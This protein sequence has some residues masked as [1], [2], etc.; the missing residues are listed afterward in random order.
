MSAVDAVGKGVLGT[1]GMMDGILGTSRMIDR[2]LRPSRLFGGIL[3]GLYWDTGERPDL[4]MI[5]RSDRPAW[6]S[7]HMDF[8]YRWTHSGRYG[9]PRSVDATARKAGLTLVRVLSRAGPAPPEF[10]KS[11]AGMAQRAAASKLFSLGRCLPWIGIRLLRRAWARVVASLWGLWTRRALWLRRD[12][13][14]MGVRLRC[15]RRVPARFVWA[16]PLR[17]HAPPVCSRRGHRAIASCV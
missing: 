12:A 4:S 5:D 6:T 14:V 2:M 7:A 3:G 11:A 8:L 9:L 15:S 10:W 16:Q 13:S 1:S 17:P